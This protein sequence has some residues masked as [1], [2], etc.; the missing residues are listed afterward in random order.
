[1]AVA[2]VH[3]ADY[4]Q[5]EEAVRKA[6]DLLGG[7]ERFVHA[8]QRVLLKANLLRA[9]DPD[10]AVSTHPSVVRAVAKL[11]KEV[12]AHS[13]IGDSPGGSFGKGALRR[14]YSRC[15]ME[16]VAEEVG[17]ELNFDTERDLVEF[18]QGRLIRAFEVGRYY[19]SADVVISLP[20]L[21]THGLMYLTGAMKNLFG[22]IPGVS[23]VSYHTRFPDRERFAMMLVDL[24]QALRPTLTLMDAVMAMEGEGPSAGRPRHVGALLAGEDP[25]ALDLV[26]ASLANMP[27]DRIPPLRIAREWGLTSGRVEDVEIRGDSLEDLR[28]PDFVPPPVGTSMHRVPAFLRAWLTRI[29]APSPHVT[30]RCIGCGVCARNC[31]A[32]AISIADKRAR[33]DLNACIRCYCCHEL[34]PEKAIDLRSPW[35]LRS[36]S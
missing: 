16:A 14:V 22:A 15:G 33:I 7:I 11:V 28:V 8:G 12:G 25:I 20:K 19:T 24:T 9:S 30:D 13:V 2:L 26:A 34:C 17:A 29:F 18:P 1:M 10:E 5:V 36:R 23:K 32:S 4:D 21:K 35:W 3:C 27:V 6:F 31:P